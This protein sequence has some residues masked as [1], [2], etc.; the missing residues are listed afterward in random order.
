MGRESPLG[1]RHDPA[2]RAWRAPLLP[3]LGFPRSLAGGEATPARRRPLGRRHLD[4]DPRRLLP[5]LH[6]WLAANTESL[7]P[8]HPIF[9]CAAGR[10]GLGACEVRAGDGLDSSGAHRRTETRRDSQGAAHR[11]VDVDGGRALGPRRHPR[12]LRQPD[13]G[14]LQLRAGAAAPRPRCSRRAS[15]CIPGSSRR[16]FGA[17]CAGSAA[18]TCLSSPTRRCSA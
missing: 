2:D 1:A 4:R 11:R 12:L 6:R 14:G 17:S 15:A 10:N 7:G 16:A 8:A 18:P 5:P 9:P 13:D 3:R